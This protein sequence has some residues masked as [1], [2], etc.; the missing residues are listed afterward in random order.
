MTDY[1]D[2]T[3]IY[4]D[5]E[6][7]ITQTGN[8]VASPTSITYGKPPLF[9]EDDLIMTEKGILL[10]VKSKTKGNRAVV[11]KAEDIGLPTCSES[12]LF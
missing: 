8:V 5:L 11:V 12:T 9:E 4:T 2:G 7:N 10:E 1:L 6:G 3:M